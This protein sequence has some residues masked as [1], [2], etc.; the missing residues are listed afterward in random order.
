MDPE[1]PR[2]VARPASL[3]AATSD[4]QPRERRQH[5]V[6]WG[7][8]ALV[9][10]TVVVGLVLGGGALVATRALGF[11]EAAST[12]DETSTASQTLYLPQPSD[13]DAPTDPLVTL[14][15]DPE[16]TTSGNG[17]GNNSGNDTSD[18]KKDKKKEKKE[19][20]ISLSA[21]QPAVGTMEPID[22][23]GVYEGGEGAILRVQQYKESG[24]DDFPV[25]APVSGTTFTT[26]IQTG[27][28]GEQ[29][30]RVVDTDTGAASNEVRV[31]VG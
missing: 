8:V 2:D 9:A 28:T 16:P 12:A 22:L 14:A 30:F 26:F 13:S 11:S 7:V 1:T 18:K 6:L 10:V 29:R 31:Q 24:W 17:G 19:K 3:D 21:A 23:S 15:G 4:E 27:Q 5:P 20:Q 25:T